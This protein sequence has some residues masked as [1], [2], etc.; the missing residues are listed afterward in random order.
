MCKRL[1]FGDN[2]S[3]FSSLCTYG[4]FN[5]TQDSSRNVLHRD[6]GTIEA[7]SNVPNQ[8]FAW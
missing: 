2:F 6:G 7:L 4:Y 1:M 8:N 3:H 5:A